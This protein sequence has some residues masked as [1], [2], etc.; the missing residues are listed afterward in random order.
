MDKKTI[1]S[2]AK[3][4]R[5]GI[6][7]REARAAAVLAQLQRHPA[8]QSAR[9]VASYVSIGTELDTS[10]INRWVI[11][12]K[13]LYLPRVVG[14]QMVF[15]AVTQLDSQLVTGS[16]QIPEPLEHLPQSEVLDVM[17]VPG[18]AFT[19]G[20]QR[21]GYGGGYYDRF[22]Q[23]STAYKIGIAFSDQLVDWLTV[24]CYDVE[25]DVVITG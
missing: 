16:Y 20:G 15:H 23:D 9:H 2:Q 10:A 17:L 11:G 1:R 24:V 13:G 19:P 21:M 8:L 18:L 7:N 22:L 25:M 6:Q 3:E 12:E 4:V 14:E 5:R